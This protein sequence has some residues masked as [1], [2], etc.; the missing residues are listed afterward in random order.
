[1]KKIVLLSLRGR[2]AYQDQDPDTIELI[3]EGTLEQTEGGWE[4][5]YQETAL[6]GM[7]GVSTTFRVEPDKIILTRTGKLNSQMIF[8][9]G[10]VHESLYQMEF[11]ALMIS[12]MAAKIRWNITEKGGTVDLL[13]AIEIENSASGTVDYHLDIQVR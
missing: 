3:T 12:V 2:Q 6:T 1:M 8:R 9:E 11:G 13:Y 7:E 4:I 10:E 5:S